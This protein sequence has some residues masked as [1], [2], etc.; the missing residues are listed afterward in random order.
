[1]YKSPEYDKGMEFLLRKI[2]INSLYSLQFQ[3]SQ[4]PL[5]SNLKKE[6]SPEDFIKH[7]K[8]FM[9]VWIRIF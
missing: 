4:E 2:Y 7:Q 1:M 8:D 9:S 5:T 6:V 3:M